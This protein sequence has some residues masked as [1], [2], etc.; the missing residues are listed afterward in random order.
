MK[1]L[2]RSGRRYLLRHP[3]QTGLA[4]LGVALG[5]AVVV[6]VDLAND[7]AL[8]A[9]RLSMETLTGRAT[10]QVYGPPGGLDER[11]YTRLRTEAGHVPAA[12]VV[13]G[14]GE[15][16][17]RTLHLLGV[18]PLAERP[19]R[20][21]LRGPG[22]DSLETLMTQP[23]TALLA[24]PTA[25][26]LGVAVGDSLPL[27]VAG[28]AT[29]LRIVGLVQASGPDAAAID[30][31][32][33]MDI[34][35]AQEAT[36]SVGLLSRIDLLLPASDG[37]AAL[38]RVQALLPRGAELAPAA[39]RTDT[40]A[41][42]SAAFRT[43][44]TAMSLLAL[45][46]GLFLIYNT[47]TFAV[48]QRR[49]LLGTLRLVG[50]TGAELFAAVLWE[51]AVI[52]LLGTVIGL[53][54]GWALGQGLVQ[55]VTRTMNDLYF[56]L[57]VTE[58]LPG[59][60]PFIK[61]ALL[62]LGGA[63]LAAA[64]P[65]LEAART[66]PLAALG[67]SHLEARVRRMAPRLAGAG[68]GMAAAAG[69]L[70]VLPSRSLLLGFVALFLLIVGLALTTPWVVARFS[71]LAGPPL[72][73]ALGVQG[74]LAVRGVADSLSRTG[75]AV[76]ALTLA[77]ATTV[78]VAVMVDSFR[79]TVAQWL[80]SSLQADVYVSLAQ[81]RSGPSRATL[82]PDLVQGIRALD[83]VAA[84]SLGRSLTLHGPGGI[85]DVFALEVPASLGPRYS[86]AEGDPETVWDAFHAGTGVAVS[87]PLAWH[88][89]LQPGDR[90]RL[91]TARGEQD[92]PVTGV[93]YDYGSERGEVL[94]TRALYQRWFDDAGVDGVGLYL[95]PGVDPAA[96]MEQVRTLAAAVAGS[97]QVRVR[98]NRELRELSLAIFDRTFT[99]TQ[100]LRILAVLVAVV[101][102]LSALMAL[103][104]ERARELAVLRATGFTPG[105]VGV[106]VTA[107]TG[108]MGLTAGL[109][110]I[111][112]GL[113][114]ALVL[115]H[116]IN[117]RS[118]GWS[119]ETVIGVEVLVQALILAV[120]AALI[121]GLLPSLR[122]AR[123]PPGEALRDE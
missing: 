23:G 108:F 50:V 94:M 74:R 115:I 28:R 19:F 8:R 17:G 120:G 118:F 46:V 106:M 86:L 15:A 40:L 96:V 9:F 62:G 18:E 111:P 67:R 41:Q 95:Q 89:Q 2:L 103:Q 55:L 99:I 66:T 82:A 32:L 92:F 53:L 58:F 11:V 21:Q 112:S 98:S 52:A 61:G 16:R 36:G 81:V 110:A 68:L 59:P 90:I 49:R 25:T 101:G 37:S 1:L 100:V 33:L 6:A 12:P 29:R 78:G 54:A 43:N 22:G 77:V 93:Y 48:L 34:A 60:L 97:Q 85:T 4:I 88:R 84:L 3:W 14:Y 117:R 72:E 114:L 70:L 75:I 122:M 109:L 76:A 20:G 51:A 83:G 79:A 42:L 121:A 44:L 119:L 80:G 56:V 13:E 102:V 7:S 73:W 105:Q 5:V 104:L 113:A 65:A 39:A 107:Q 87:E 27:T 64:A 45:L 35:T 123:T 30:G 31:L 24:A 71:R 57:T 63:L 69:A 26:R 47:M 10:H 38:A 116:V 91:R